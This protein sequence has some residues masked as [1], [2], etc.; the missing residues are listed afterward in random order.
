[1]DGIII[2]TDRHLKIVSMATLKPGDTFRYINSDE[3]QVC[4]VTEIKDMTLHYHSGNTF[5]DDTN[6]L[7]YPI[8][9]IL[10]TPEVEK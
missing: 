6:S 3:S 8:N 4:T 5:A 9:V 10:L 2:K 1:M 7:R